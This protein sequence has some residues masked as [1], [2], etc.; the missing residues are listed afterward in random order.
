MLRDVQGYTKTALPILENTVWHSDPKN[1]AKEVTSRYT[2]ESDGIRKASS[3][4]RL[5]PSWL[6]LWARATVLD[7]GDATAANLPD[8]GD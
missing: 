1:A 8:L 7:L 5:R 4:L 6:H 2:H 3:V